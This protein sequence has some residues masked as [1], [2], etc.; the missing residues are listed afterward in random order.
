M[1]KCCTAGL[2]NY[3]NMAL[4]WYL[5]L[6]YLVPNKVE[7]RIFVPVP[8]C[9]RP[10]RRYCRID[11]GS[12]PGMYRVSGHPC[13]LLFDTVRIPFRLCIASLFVYYVIKTC[14][15]LKWKTDDASGIQRAVVQSGN[16]G[17][18]HYV[19]RPETGVKPQCF[20]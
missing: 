8:S 19:L 7:Y 4:F 11:T 2:G 18:G 20:I 13:H 1:D 17:E 15:F 14:F 9:F 10:V 3:L 5:L 16:V 6:Y 12:C